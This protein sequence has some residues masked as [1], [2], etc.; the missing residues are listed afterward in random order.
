MEKCYIKVKWHKRDQD[1]DDRN[2]EPETEE[3]ERV[4]VLGEVESA[5]TLEM[6]T[7]ASK[8]V[9]FY[10]GLTQVRTRSYIFNRH[11]YVEIRTRTIIVGYKQHICWYRVITILKYGYISILKINFVMKDQ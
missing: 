2:K 5:L 9:L 3:E 8:D 11:Q 1:E 7:S 10:P 6:L 4:R